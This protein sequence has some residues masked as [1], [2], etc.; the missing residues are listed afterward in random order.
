MSEPPAPGD[1]LG[2]W[3]VLELIGRGGSGSVYRVRR[4]GE[5]AARAAKV[6]HASLAGGEAARLRFAREVAVLARTRHPRVTG[7]IE[8][9]AEPDGRMV[10]VSELARGPG[11]DAWL[12]SH[13]AGE[14]PVPLATVL[15]LARDMALG[16]AHLHGAGVLH[17]DLKPSNVVVEAGGRARLVDLGLARA[18]T[19]DT[20][21]T[22]PGQVR[23]TLRYTAPEVLLKQAPGPAADLYG[24]GLVVHELLTGRPVVAH[25][26]PSA[27]A[28]AHLTEIPSPP[29]VARPGLPAWWDRITAK[30]LAKDPAARYAS[31][32]RVLADLAAL[33]DDLIGRVRA[34]AAARRRA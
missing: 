10:I 5:R 15:A 18:A 7:C 11:L 17:R 21:V 9:F 33:R 28:T 3:I 24:L 27:I 20:I 30:L 8:A 1:S 26:S 13:G 14:R 16:L 12:A 19:E 32:D 2:P 6:M 25:R 29:S 31:A 23:A 34:P 22:Q 4:P